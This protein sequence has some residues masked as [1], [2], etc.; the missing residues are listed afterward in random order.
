M[1]TIT[2]ACRQRDVDDIDGVAAGVKE[3]ALNSRT[4]TRE[5]TTAR[6]SA[7]DRRTGS[8]HIESELRDHGIRWSTDLAWRCVDG[9]RDDYG[10]L[11]HLVRTLEQTVC[12]CRRRKRWQVIDRERERE[13]AGRG[14]GRSVEGAFVVRE[15]VLSVSCID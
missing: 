8:G 14:I 3:P 6:A 7:G 4:F 1:L 13:R 15:R 5:A 12:V 11:E 10:Q 2:C 9:V